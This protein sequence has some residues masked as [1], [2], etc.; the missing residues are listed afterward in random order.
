[1]YKSFEL[2]IKDYGGVYHLRGE[3]GILQTVWL[4]TDSTDTVR[5]SVITDGYNEIIC[6]LAVSDDTLKIPI[7][8][9]VNSK[10][11]RV[12]VKTEKP[13]NTNLIITLDYA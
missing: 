7:S 13:V 9:A 12:V 6:D 11:L 8:I 3:K 4:S 5:V 1:M 10:S 2:D